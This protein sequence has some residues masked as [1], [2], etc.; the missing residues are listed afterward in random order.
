MDMSIIDTA[1][2]A[3]SSERTRMD[4]IAANI[5]NMHTT[6]D[7]DGNYNPYKRKVVQFENVLDQ[8]TGL[9]KGIAVNKVVDDQTEMKKIYDPGHPNADE[10][11]Y[12]DYP[13]VS[14][15]REMVDMASSKATYEANIKAIQV[16]KTMFNAALE[17]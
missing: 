8:K 6:H 11:G 13:N 17:I 15:E 3:I 16:F 10:M 9:S 12:V 4:I 2:S 14:I 5:A 7:V 1:G